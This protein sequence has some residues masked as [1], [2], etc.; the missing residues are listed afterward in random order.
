MFSCACNTWSNIKTKTRAVEHVEGESWKE[1]VKE[2]EGVRGK[3]E[4][5]TE[6]KEK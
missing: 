1:G 2:K 5:R 4:Y 3:K 6:K